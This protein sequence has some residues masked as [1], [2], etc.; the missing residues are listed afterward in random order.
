MARRAGQDWERPILPWRL[1]V[2]IC[3]HFAIP[4]YLIFLLTGFLLSPVPP[5]GAEQG[6]RWILRESGYF[7]VGFVLATVAGGLIA[8]LVDP[9]LRAWRRFRRTRDPERAAADSR[10]QLD[11]ALRRIGAANW[12]DRSTRIAA[13]VARLTGG[14]WH[15]Q[16]PDAQ[17]LTR[18]LGEAAEAFVPALQGAQGAR[19]AELAEMS[20]R[21]FERIADALEEQQAVKS[22]LDE[23]DARTIA[24]LI[25]LRYGSNR[26][27]VSL[28]RPEEQE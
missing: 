7:L 9:P 25:D 20:V 2:G 24:R 23:G 11:T 1:V 5:D 15:H 13:A 21:A 18:D 3:L 16:D 14:T 10:R 22:R 4:A 27:P 17:R 8:A 12:G 6:V 19:R 28:D 26:S